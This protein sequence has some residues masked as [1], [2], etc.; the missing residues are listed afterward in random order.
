[1]GEGPGFVAV[2]Q[3]PEVFAVG[4]ARASPGITPAARLA[5]R[6]TWYLHCQPMY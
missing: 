6:L 4:N 3:A 1:M 2:R 5:D